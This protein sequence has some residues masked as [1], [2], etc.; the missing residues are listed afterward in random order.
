MLEFLATS[1]IQLLE[2]IRVNP[3]VGLM[4]MVCVLLIIVIIDIKRR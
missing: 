2:A 4:V 1:Y 3:S